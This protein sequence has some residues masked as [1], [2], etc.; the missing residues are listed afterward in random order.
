MRAKDSGLHP[1]DTLPLRLPPPPPTCLGGCEYISAGPDL[2]W[3][4]T[5]GVAGLQL[6]LAA[7]GYCLG[8]KLYFL[9]WYAPALFARLAR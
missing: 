3:I 7:T 9:R 1:R 4:L 5:A 2:G 6:T 8:C